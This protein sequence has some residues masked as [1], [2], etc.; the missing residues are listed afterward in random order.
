MTYVRGLLLSLLIA[1][2][3]IFVEDQVALGAHNPIAHGQIRV[4]MLPSSTVQKVLPVDQVPSNVVIDVQGGRA[5]ILTYPLD[6]G[7]RHILVVATHTGALVRTVSLRGPLEAIA[8]VATTQRVFVISGRTIRILDART[9]ILLP[10]IISMCRRPVSLVVASRMRRVFVG[11]DDG[12]LGTLDAVTGA[13][14]RVSRLGG[15][16]TIVVHEQTGHVLVIGQDPNTGS[17]VL[18]FMLDAATGAILH[19]N[20]LH[21]APRGTT[22]NVGSEHVFVISGNAV[23]MIDART[24]QIDYSTSVG[25][26]PWSILES[27]PLERVY[28][29]TGTYFDANSDPNELG[30]VSTLDARTGKIVRNLTLGRAAFAFSPS[31]IAVDPVANRVWVLST[32]RHRH[33]GV[34]VLNAETG[35]LLHTLYPDADALPVAIALDT[36]AERLIE[37]D[38]VLK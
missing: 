14:L 30:T 28:V 23:S 5:F 27:T 26:H 33:G 29:L 19:E 15:T 31:A 25:V 3:V 10:S 4:I 24:G 34:S 16:L 7:L 1:V 38:V 17:P 18:L 6:N 32:D 13:V 20:Y 9:G 37:A 35:T 11:C 8:V 12:S 21:H 22:A 36:Q 2:L